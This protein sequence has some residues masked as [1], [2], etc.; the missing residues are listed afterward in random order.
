MRRGDY[1]VFAAV[2]VAFMTS[3]YLW[4]SGGLDHRRSKESPETVKD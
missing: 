3:V 2:L 4:F 1:A